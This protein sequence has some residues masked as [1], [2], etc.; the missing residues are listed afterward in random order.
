MNPTTDVFEKRVAALEGGAA[1]LATAS[2]QAAETLTIITLA[3]R[4]RRDRLHH[5]ALRRHLQPL[6][7]HA[8]PAG[9]HRALCRCRR[10][11]RPA[12]GHQR[13]DARRL[14]RN[15]RQSQARRR[16]YREAR[17]HRPRAQ[18]AAD[19]R[20]HLRARRLWCG[21][22]SG[23]RTSSSTRPPSSSAA[24][25]R[26][27]RRHRRR[28]QVRLGRLGP[29]QGL[30]RAR[31]LLSRPLATPKP[32]ARWR[33]SSK[34]ASRA[35][36]TPARRFRPSTRSCSCRASRRCTCAWSA[37]RK[38]AGRG[39]ASGAASRRGVGQLSRPRIQP[40]LRA[41]QEVP[42]QRRRRRWSPSASRAATT[43][44]RS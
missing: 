1:G 8:A 24:T 7:L 28:R 14:Y 44:A 38:R 37:T 15:A 39:Q 41:G 6:P 32:S 19:H 21:P 34:R 2:G 4:R 18:A 31:S 13:K 20:Q 11:R 40:L 25:A 35:C 23:A 22:S 10:L 33:S 3:E 9:H 43:P 12:R 27:R 36:A 5:L 26:H 29:L 42:A 16:R 30:H 17:R